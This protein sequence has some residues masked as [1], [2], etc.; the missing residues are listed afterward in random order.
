MT[1]LRAAVRAYLAM[2][3]DLGFHLRETGR[4]LLQFVAFMEQHRATTITTRLA[5]AWA[6]QPQTVQPAEWAR[7]LS[8]V[9]IFARYRHAFDPQTEIPPD[10]LLPYRPKRA[11]PYRYSDE[12]IRRLVRAART[13]PYHYQRGALRPWVYSCLFG[14][15]SVSGLRLGDA[16]NLEL[17]DVDLQAAVLTIRGAK[18]GKTRLVPLHPSACTALA[19]YLR[20][21]QQHWKGRPV[22]S[23]VFVS[24]AGNRVDVGDIH[25]TFYALSRQI[26][27]RG[28]T[29]RHGPR[30]HDLRHRFAAKTLWRWYR[31]GEDPERRLPV[32]SAYLGHV[33]VA[34]TYWYL[35]AWPELMREAMRRLERQWENRP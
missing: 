24:S 26:G 2:R 12:E 14:L 13:M 27:L 23:Y 4:L 33:H 22:S 8:M 18:F 1:T 19:D 30:I 17:H 6:Q 5:L 7:R 20:R 9:R 15:L 28:H 16:R 11:R 3:R 32:L 35:S 10:G 25:R 29:D 34:D 21:R 31:T